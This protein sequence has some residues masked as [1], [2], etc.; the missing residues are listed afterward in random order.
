RLHQATGVDELKRAALHWVD[1]TLDSRDAEGGVAGFETWDA[2]HGE[3]V[4][5]PG[6]LQGAAGVALALA[7]ATSDV[8][9]EWDR[10]LLTS[11]RPNVP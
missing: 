2:E 8:E 6:F 10:A 3:H 1:H 11:A 4:A 7:S 9:P 5:H